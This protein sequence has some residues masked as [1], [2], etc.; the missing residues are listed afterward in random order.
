LNEVEVRASAGYK[1][2]LTLNRAATEQSLLI[3]SGV[4]VTI[5]RLPLDGKQF[6][7]L[8]SFDDTR[9]P[10]GRDVTHEDFLFALAQFKADVS[11]QARLGLDARYVFQDQVVDT[12][13]TETNLAATAVLGHG[14]ALVPNARW[15]LAGA[16]WLELSGTAQ[17]QYYE[18]PLDDYWEGGPKLMLG[19]DYGHRS[20][21][22]L[23]GAWMVRGY[24]TREQVSL[25]GTNIPGTSLDF[26]QYQ[27]ELAWRHHWDARRRWRTATRLEFQVNQDN[28]PGFYDYRRY[29]ASQQIHYVAS[30]WEI[31]AQARVSYYDFEFQEVSLTN[32]ELRKKAIVGASLRAEKKLGKHWSLFAE[33][34]YEQSLSNR[35]LDEYRSN[36]VA[37]GVGLRF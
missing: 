12:S 21:I 29:G 1:D 34:E 16:T 7:F 20:S 17:R 26:S 23:A 5:A 25:S 18:E 28:G 2:N 32:P 37:S 15:N 10:Q 27:A 33:Y 13:V 36:R 4:D 22:T 30:T 6:N 9:Y 24:D 35:D 8:L 19:H 14:F 3:G 31:R 11:A